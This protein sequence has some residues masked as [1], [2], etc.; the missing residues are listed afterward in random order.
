MAE[1]NVLYYG[2]N[3]DVLRRH[4]RN[5]SVDLVYLGGSSETWKP[6]IHAASTVAGGSAL[7]HAGPRFTPKPRDEISSSYRR[8]PYRGIDRNAVDEA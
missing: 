4:V 7:S 5:E 6:Y 2:D 1:P 8:R 3:L